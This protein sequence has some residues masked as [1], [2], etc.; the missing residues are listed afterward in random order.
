M[1]CGAGF[2]T[3]EGAKYAKGLRRNNIRKFTGSLLGHSH[4]PEEFCPD[5]IP[6]LLII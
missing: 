4:P 5:K 2:F 3:A 6:G 1:L